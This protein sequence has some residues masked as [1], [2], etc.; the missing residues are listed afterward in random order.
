VKHEF[1]G[2]FGRNSSL[3]GVRSI[4]FRRFAEPFFHPVQCCSKPG[5]CANFESATNRD[6]MN[7]M[8]ASPYVEAAMYAGL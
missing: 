7:G 5:Y 4:S 1:L 2:K 3:S 6:K 8:A